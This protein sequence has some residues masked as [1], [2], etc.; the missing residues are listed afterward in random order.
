MAQEFRFTESAEGQRKNKKCITGRIDTFVEK[1]AGTSHVILQPLSDK[2]TWSPISKR[3]R[4]N[5][6]N[7]PQVS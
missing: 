3:S 5:M 1:H 4:K 2:P 7:T 6:S